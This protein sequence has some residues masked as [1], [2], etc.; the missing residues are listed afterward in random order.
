MRRMLSEEQLK[1][2]ILEYAPG[3]SGS[4][5]ITS[6]VVLAET[7]SLAQGQDKQYTN[8]GLSKLQTYDLIILNVIHGAGVWTSC[9]IPANLIKIDVPIEVTD[10]VMFV[11][12]TANTSTLFN[13]SATAIHEFT[14]TCIKY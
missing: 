7:E 4:G 9:V 3:G 5:G 10:N 11:L 14:I 1:N 8:L 12:N 2:K 6:E 13:S